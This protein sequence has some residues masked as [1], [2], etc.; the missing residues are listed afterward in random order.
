[1]VIAKGQQKQRIFQQHCTRICLD[2]SFNSRIIFTSFVSHCPCMKSS[3]YAT[4]EKALIDTQTHAT[5]WL[6]PKTLHI[7]N[8]LMFINR[9][10]I[11]ACTCLSHFGAV[12][13]KH[14]PKHKK[15]Y[16]YSYIQGLR[17]CDC[18]WIKQN[19]KT[20]CFCFVFGS[21]DSWLYVI[22]SISGQTFFFGS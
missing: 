7:N 16:C 8:E 20:F 13:L 2:I 6:L 5:L 21:F 4:R 15:K 12:I 18:E 19:I 9:I 3:K 22:L 17:S 14:Y 10:V 1:M 11:S